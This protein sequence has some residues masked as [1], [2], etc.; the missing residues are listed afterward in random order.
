MNREL[1]A[2]FV[3]ISNFL[4]GFHE[5]RLGIIVAANNSEFLKKVDKL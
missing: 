2:L 5:F 1:F 4:D 3:D